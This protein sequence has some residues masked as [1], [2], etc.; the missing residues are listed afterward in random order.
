MNEE[1][2]KIPVFNLIVAILFLVAVFGLPLWM[3]IAD[4][5]PAVILN[6]FQAGILRGSYYPMM[7]YLLLMLGIALIGVIIILVVNK[8]SLIFTGKKEKTTS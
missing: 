3:L 2:K 6:K 1:K 5:W 7:T 8:I 4:I